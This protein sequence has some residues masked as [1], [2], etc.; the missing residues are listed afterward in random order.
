MA[1]SGV[2]AFA[3]AK[4]SQIL[5]ETFGWKETLIIL[6]SLILQCCLLGAFLRPVPTKPKPKAYEEKTVEEVHTFSGSVLSLNE[7]RNISKKS[8]TGSL[9]LNILK[10]MGNVSLLSKN[11]GLLFIT[12]SNFFI[13]SGYFI[14]FLFIPIRA[15]QLDIADSSFILG[16]IGL[17]N[18]PSRLGFGFLADIRFISPINLNTMCV[19]LACGS[20]WSYFLLNT[21]AL[22][23]LFAVLFGTGIGGINCITTPYIKDIVGMENFSNAMGI[24]NLFRGVGCFLGPFLGGI[25]SEQFSV[26]AAF[27]YS[28]I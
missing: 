13:F 16:L 7:V 2:G 17:V 26:V 23:L 10:E 21:Y 3:F 4:F 9:I 1:G 28:S 5:V 15:K 14:P 6:G 18:I 27:F 25:I 12:L 22:Q 11:I 24:I 8:G 20:L 19:I